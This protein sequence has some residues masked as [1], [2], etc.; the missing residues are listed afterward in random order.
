MNYTDL[1]VAGTAGY[2]AYRI[3]AIVAS[4]AG[5]LLA[6]CEGR[7]NSLADDGDIDLLLRRSLDGGETWGPTETVY[8]DGPDTIG[9]PCPVIDEVSGDICLTFCRNN[10]R[11]YVTRSAD[12]GR[13][14]AEPADITDRVKLPEWGLIGTGPGHGIQ[15]KSGRLLVPCWAH[16]PGYAFP[17]RT[18]CIHSDDGGSTWNRGECVP[19]VDWGDEAQAVELPDGSIY[20]NIR[21]KKDKPFRA[22][23]WSHDG[24]QS[25]SEVGWH[26]DIPEPYSCQ[27]SV[28]GLIDAHHSMGIRGL[29]CNPAGPAREQLT[30]RASD[31]GCRTWSRGKVVWHGPAAYSDMCVLP[32]GTVCCLFERGQEQPYEAISLSRFDTAWAAHG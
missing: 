24:G 25:W 5:T 13:S 23:A 6:F 32:D 11:V 27:G 31:D 30:I 29:V 16:P 3:P 9:N 21:A 8:N 4:G 22:H 1:F 15:L 20:L 10:N 7:R 28:L 14:W 26:E 19:G 17:G 2:H 12:D 18:L